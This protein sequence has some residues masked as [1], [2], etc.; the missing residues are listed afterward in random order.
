MPRLLVWVKKVI[1]FIEIQKI[2]VK[3]G[4]R[5]KSRIQYMLSLRYFCVIL[6]TSIL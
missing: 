3:E 4:L 1:L 2:G 6:I 5:E